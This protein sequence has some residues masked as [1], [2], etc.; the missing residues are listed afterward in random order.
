MVLRNNISTCKD[1]VETLLYTIQAY[2]LKLIIDLNIRS[3]TLKVL[4]KEFTWGKYS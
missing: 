4:E 2:Y 1:E 3:R